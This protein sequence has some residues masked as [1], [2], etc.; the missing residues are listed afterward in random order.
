M[1]VAILEIRAFGLIAAYARIHGIPLRAGQTSDAF[2]RELYAANV[3]A[4]RERYPTL[5][6]SDIPPLLELPIL[7]QAEAV[8]VTAAI[9]LLFY[10]AEAYLTQDLAQD[11]ETIIRHIEVHDAA[12]PPSDTLH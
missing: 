8:D 10:N 1:S 5:S 11:L 9:D 2:A 3:K 6:A 12:W 7:N 4:M